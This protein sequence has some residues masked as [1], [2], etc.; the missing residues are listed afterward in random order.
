[1][2]LTPALNSALSSLLVIEKQ[3]SVVSTNI[4]NADVTGYTSKTVDIATQVTGG[5]GTGVSTTGIS[6]TVDQNLTRDI[7]AASSAAGYADT[8]NSYYQVLAEYVGELSS[9]SGSTNLSSMLSTLESD[10]SNLANTPSSATYQSQVVSDLDT[11]ASTL[12]DTSSQVQQ[13]RSQA[14]SSIASTVQDINSNL[15]EIADLNAQI[16]AASTAGQSTADLED[17]RTTALENLSSDINVSYFV[18]STGSMQVYTGSGQILVD[19]TSAH[20]LSYTSAGAVSSG[21]T[22]S[23]S[24]SSG[25]DAIE[26]DGTDITTSVQ[27]GKLKALIDLRDTALPDAQSELDS[28]ASSLASTMN[29]IYNQGTSDPPPNS[30]TGSATVAASDAFSATGTVRVAVVDSSG[31][32]SS[33][34]DLDLS[35]YSTVS[36]VVSALNSISGV[37][38]SIDSSGHLVIQA[39]DSSEGIAINEMTSSVGSTGSGFSDY[40]GLNDLLT[41]GSSAATIAVRSDILSSSSLLA[42]S[43]LD[44]SSTLTTGT[45]VVSSGSSTIA[46]DLYDALSAQTSFSAAGSL[47]ATTASFADYAGDI[48]SSIS[49]ASSN[50]STAATNKDTALSTLQTSYSNETGVNTDTETAKLTTLQSQYAAAAKVISTLQ[51][52]FQDLLDAVKG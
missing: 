23:A 25:F 5:E 13:L 16:R 45:T 26:V 36:D 9:S 8:Y 27:S 44:A 11:L 30:L 40:F 15:S 43:T 12:R 35:G 47:G 38:A 37:S 31:D 34:D 42:T 20:T 28:L 46:T 10:L 6:S 14:D 50:A 18:D 52:M 41:G 49:T 2:S 22:Y 4:A 39:T 17:Q 19:G 1:M 32:V 24:G 48:I 3:M 21:T 33:Y 51:T 29:A 7:V